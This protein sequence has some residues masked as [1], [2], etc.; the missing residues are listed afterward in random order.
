VYDGNLCHIARSRITNTSGSN[1]C[2]VVGSNISNIELVYIINNNSYGNVSDWDQNYK[3]IYINSLR[4]K[5]I[6]LSDILD[7]SYMLYGDK[8]RCV[9]IRSEEDLTITV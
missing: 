4:Y 1:I 8:G 7:N 5:T 6:T 3:N 9:H 2:G